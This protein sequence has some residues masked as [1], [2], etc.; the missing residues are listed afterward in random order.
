MHIPPHSLHPPTTLNPAQVGDIDTEMLL[1]YRPEE[2]ALPRPAYAV[3]L[4]TGGSGGW[5]AG[6]SG[7]SKAG[8]RLRR[9][10]CMVWWCAVQSKG[11]SA[12]R[13]LARLKVDNACL[14]TSPLLQTWAA[15]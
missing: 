1:W 13:S 12:A 10:G 15:R 2:Q 9:C 6:C 11:P 4:T 7:A 14:M 8:E 3:D 5:E